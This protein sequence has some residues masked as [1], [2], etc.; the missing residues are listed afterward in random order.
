MRRLLMTIALLLS[1]AACTTAM[2]SAQCDR[3]DA[4]SMGPENGFHVTI[5]DDATAALDGAPSR[6]D[7]AISSAVPLSGPVTLVQSR[8][9]REVARWS[10][11][12]PPAAGIVKRCSLGFAA[13]SCGSVLGA[14]PQTA[15]GDWTIQAGANQLL[16][17]SIAFRH[18]AG[19]RDA[20]QR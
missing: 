12:P 7:V 15:G 5:P 14:R 18:C 13:S 9:G 8:A 20:A 19:A 10:V 4:P 16:E 11:A 1:S 17:A 3:Y 6:I 2:K